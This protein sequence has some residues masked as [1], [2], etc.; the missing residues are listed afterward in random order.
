MYSF[1]DC[2]S[3]ADFTHSQ[4][5]VR[6]QQSLSQVQGENEELAA[7]DRWTSAG[8][9]STISMPHQYRSQDSRAAIPQCLK[10]SAAYAKG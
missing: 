7:S 4:P 6:S 1:I 2:G 8:F 3:T 10:T 5:L 9:W